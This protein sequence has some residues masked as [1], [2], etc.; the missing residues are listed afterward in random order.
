MDFLSRSVH[1]APAFFLLLA[2]VLMLPSC[3]SS[4]SMMDEME[5]KGFVTLHINFETGKA[6]I[7]P[8]SQGIIDQ[9]VELLSENDTLS[10]SIEGHTDNTGNAASNKTLSEN[11]ARAVMNALVARG[12][13]KSRLST[14]GWGQ[15][16]PIADNKTDEG[17]A[18]NRRVEIVRK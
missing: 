2:V 16:K 18:K 1:C 4:E 6:D 11:R 8:E 13:I 9:V 7:R 10:I 15:E 17:R 3:S 12:I 14:K 5:S